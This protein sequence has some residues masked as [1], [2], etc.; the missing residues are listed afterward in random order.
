MRST[1]TRRL[2]G[3]ESRKNIAGEQIGIQLVGRGSRSS[4]HEVAV[5]IY[6]IKTLTPS[7]VLFS[8]SSTIMFYK[9]YRS[10]KLNIHKIKIIYIQFYSKSPLRGADPNIP[11]F[12]APG[13][14]TGTDCL[15]ARRGGPT[16]R[17]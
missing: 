9:A 11:G 3:T 5:R 10:I 1:A 13:R 2:V 16:E 14:L 4:N 15:S 8:I 12:P 6:F 17:T 7:G